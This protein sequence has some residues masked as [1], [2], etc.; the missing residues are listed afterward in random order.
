LLASTEFF[1]D[2]GQDRALAD[3]GRRADNCALS[4]LANGRLAAAMF[5][6]R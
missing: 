6:R 3:I 1:N 2:I 5:F 4:R